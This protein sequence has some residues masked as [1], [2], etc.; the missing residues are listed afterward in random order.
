[1][2]PRRLEPLQRADQLVVVALVEPDRGLVEDVE[3]ADELRAD[4]RR[5]AEPL[6]LTPR[7]RLC[8]AVELEIA[9]ADIGEERESLADLLHDPVA[10][11]LLGRRQAEVV[12]EAERGFDGEAGEL[13]D[14]AVPDRDGQHRGLEPRAVALG[15][16][17]ERHVLLDPLALLARIG[18]AVAPL[19]IPQDALER[20]RVLALAAHPVL[21]L[22]EDPVAVRAVEEPV[23]LLL[24]EL[25]P[26]QI[27]VD[28][29]AVGDRLDHA[30]VEARAPDR[31][32]HERAVGDRD[33]G[34]GHEH[35]RVDL[36]LG[37]EPGAARAGT[38]RRVER[39]DARLELGQRD[40]V[41]GAGEVLRVEEA[42]AVDDIDPDEALG[43]RGGRLDR[44]GESLAEVVLEHEPVDHDLDRV[45]E[46]LVEHDL[47][48]EQPLLAVD[49]DAREAVATELLEHVAELA[50]AVAHDRSVDREARSLRQREDLLDD[51]VEALA[52][53]RAPADRAVRPADARVQKAQVVVDLR[54]RAHRRARVARR[55]L[56]VDRDRRREPVDRVDVGLLHHLQELARVGGERLDVAAL[57]LGVD[58]VERERRLAGARQPGDADERVARQPHRDVFQIVLPG[59]VDD[60]LFD[61]HMT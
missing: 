3:D 34:V 1:M 31:P 15:A 43:E 24:G 55:G 48:L 22:D 42:L 46:L 23:L 32:R 26:R 40:A 58:R 8:G 21:V 28:L 44:L 59:A 49:L 2:L 54:H 16:G 53:D 29:V 6:G 36:E 60:E 45:L 38:V 9:D 56:L 41:L 4:L 27:G 18:L 50:L 57:P 19:E 37:A 35:V 33:R 30:L 13:V 5:E 12:E 47:V 17:P 25:A 52:R 39:E 51:L 11:Q 7:Q 14:R 20:H 10:D 61:G